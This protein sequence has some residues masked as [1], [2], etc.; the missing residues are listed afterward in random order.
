MV[1]DGLYS[2]R[3]KGLIVRGDKLSIITYG[4]GVQWAIE[5][6]RSLPETLQNSVEIADLNL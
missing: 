3:S 4:L 1:D 2:I 5:S 6:V